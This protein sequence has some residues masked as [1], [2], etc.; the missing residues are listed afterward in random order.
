MYPFTTKACF[1]WVL[2]TN[3]IFIIFLVNKF[4]EKYKIRKY[5]VRGMQPFLI[6]ALY[7]ITFKCLEKGRCFII[8]ST[9]RLLYEEVIN[10]NLRVLERKLLVLLNRMF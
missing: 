3:R 2:G 7:K 4:Y 9:C 6:D 1:R 5:F 10:K 8:N